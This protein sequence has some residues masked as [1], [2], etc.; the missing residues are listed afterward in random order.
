MHRNEEQQRHL[1]QIEHAVTT[2]LACLSMVKYNIVLGEEQKKELTADIETTLQ[3]LR[4]GLIASTSVEASGE[5]PQT[6]ITSPP[7]IELLPYKGA[8]C[9]QDTHSLHA[10]YRAY[11]TYLSINQG[12]ISGDLLVR[13]NETM[14]IIDS[15]QDIV[16]QSGQRYDASRNTSELQNSLEDPLHRVRGFIADLYYM[17]VE[18][19]RALSEVLQEKEVNT[20]EISSM[21]RL[22]E[23]TEEYDVRGI[24]HLSPLL[25]AYE[26]HQRFCERKGTIAQRVSEAIAFLEFLEESLGSN[27]SKR[28]EITAQINKVAKLLHDLSRLLANYES[29]VITILGQ[30]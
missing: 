24:Q 15:V 14:S 9:K 22:A 29:V 10:I 19:M 27:F 2:V 17:F 13:F 3:F 30:H 1:S 16:E 11:D 12:N 7:H 28:D 8:S 23:S 4:S 21:Q 26:I 25:S 18:F 6:Q 5:V 20:E